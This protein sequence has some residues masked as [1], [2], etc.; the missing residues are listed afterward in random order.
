MHNSYFF[1]Q[2]LVPRLSQYL[3]DSVLVS[4]FSQEK[5]ELVLEFNNGTRSFFLRV[6]FS[7]ELTIIVFPEKY[8]RARNNSADIFP[9]LIMSRVTGVQLIE[10]E[11]TFVITLN[12]NAK[13]LFRMHGSSGN[14]LLESQNH[15]EAFRKSVGSGLDSNHINKPRKINWSF[16]FF[17]QHQAGIEKA[18]FIFGK[19]VWRWLRF[20]EYDSLEL[21]EKFKLIGE[22][23]TLLSQ[24]IFYLCRENGIPFFSLL[25]FEHSIKI[26]S[27]PVTAVNEFYHILVREKAFHSLRQSLLKRQESRLR[28]MKDLVGKSQR[29]HDELSA[30][31]HF[32]EWADLIMVH[33]HEIN[34]GTE[35]FKAE[36]FIA[37]GEFCEIRLK[38]GLS[39]QKNA[40]IYYRK[41]RNREEE[42]QRLAEQLSQISISIEAEQERLKKIQEAADIQFLRTIES[43]MPADREKQKQIKRLPYLEFETMGF[44]VLVGRSSSENDELT[45]KVASRDDLWLH[46]R[47]VAGSHVVIRNQPGK[48]IPDAVIERAAALAAFHSK[49]KG[50]S[51]CPVAITRRK[52]VRK[53]KGDPPGTVIVERE[54]VRMAVPAP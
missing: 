9:S 10:N 40:E 31:D 5:D 34:P 52:Y 18:Y 36:R 19:E 14:I 44:K 6:I 17:E 24:P 37:P 12:N 22:C 46:V 42:F 15:Y 2:C 8:S 27:D 51:L 33:L 16:D 28:K 26:D 47:D 29:R 50:E 25:P 32:R 54:E 3:T 4:C 35:I 38:P 13:I 7:P 30:G 48:V 49:R 41:A 23:K 11:R 1:Y 20:K 43:Q 45:F 53:R 39:P 21:K